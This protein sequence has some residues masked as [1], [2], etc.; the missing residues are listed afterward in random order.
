[1]LREVVEEWFTF[2]LP[3]VI[4]RDI[5]YTL[6]EGSALALVGPRRAG[7]TYFMYWI[8]Q[9]LMSRGWPREAIVYINLEDVRLSVLRPTDFGAFLKVVSEESREY[10]GKVLLMLDEVQNLPEWGRWVRTLL[11]RGRY[12]VIVSGSSSRVRAGEVATEL[13]GRY[14]DRLV[15]PFSFREFLRARGFG[16]DF[17][18]APERR[19]RLLGHLRDYVLNGAL[20]EIVLRP[21][22]A[23]DLVRTYRETIVYRDVVDRYRIRDVTFFETFLELVENSF[24]GYVS[25]TKLNNY[26]R[27][28]GINKSKRTL[29]NYLR[30]LE[31]AYY[32]ILV[33]KFGFTT[34]EILQQPRK[35]YPIDTAYFRRKAIGPMMEGVVAVELMRRGLNYGYLRI[36][37]YEVDF[38]INREPREYVQ[39]TYASAMDEIDRREFRA[40]AR[41]SEALGR[42]I[43]RVIT[44]DLEGE[45]TVNGI[46]I[47]MTPLWKWLLEANT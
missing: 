35:V 44:W 40:L 13:R 7:K 33:R 34:R 3:R 14:V 46:K 27:S 4:P 41:A 24:G 39:V 47:I 6:I 32:V 11:D 12:Y 18:N 26:F 31:E 42:G 37:D 10:N 30:Y 20:P 23:S 22:L 16:L 21:E 45:V 25:I 5:P 43:A 17:L 1:M 8:A 2:E 19:G 36:N 28:L 38:V 9:D 15:L 29:S